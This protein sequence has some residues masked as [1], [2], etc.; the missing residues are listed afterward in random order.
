MHESKNRRQVTR[1]LLALCAGMTLSDSGSVQGANTSLQVVDLVHVRVMAGAH[2]G[3][4][5]CQKTL[6]LRPSFAY[7]P[8]DRLVLPGLRVVLDRSH[9]EHWLGHIWSTEYIADE[10]LDRSHM[11]RWIGH[12]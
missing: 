9:M 12:I 4:G 5:K 2:V 8:S 6:Q 3:P 11:E 1:V 10:A 7:Q